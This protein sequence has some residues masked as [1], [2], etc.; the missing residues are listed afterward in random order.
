MSTRG[1]STRQRILEAACPLFIE[2]GYRSVTMKDICQTS[3]LSRGGLYGHFD[4]PEQVFLEILR[5]FPDRKRFWVAKQIRQ[6]VPAPKILDQMLQEFEEALSSR[7]R[8]LMLPICEYF[9]DPAH[10][11]TGNLILEDSRQ[12]RR[13]WTELVQYGIRR[14]EFHQTDPEALFALIASSTLGL[15][16]GSRLVEI[17]PD[18]PVRV[19][20]LIRRI[21][22]WEA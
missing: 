16:V 15:Q 9:S 7:R 10:Q 8:T 22:V 6:E 19:G 18:T 11:G 17:E 2:K 20:A 3:G 12:T 21:L 1:E 13:V 4:S 14:G 5:R